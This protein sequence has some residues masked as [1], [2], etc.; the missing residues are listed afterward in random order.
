MS[1][2]PLFFAE[3]R[4]EVLTNKVFEVILCR[5]HLRN[6]IAPIVLIHKLDSDILIRLF[7][8][9]AVAVRQA[10]DSSYV[11]LQVEQVADD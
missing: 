4:S 2:L 11:H 1:E 10:E 3:V 5:A 9:L 6:W 8:H 7:T